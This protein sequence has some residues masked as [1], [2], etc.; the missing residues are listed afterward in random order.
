M[1]EIDV[2]YNVRIVVEKV[3]HVPTKTEPL[4]GVH[5]RKDVVVESKRIVTEAGKVDLKHTDFETVKD[6]AM[7]HLELLTE[8]EGNDPRKGNNREF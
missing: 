1:A 6:L 7:K 2:H 8:F 3:M 4:A 5:P